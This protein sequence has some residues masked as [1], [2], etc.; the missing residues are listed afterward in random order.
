MIIKEYQKKSDID[1]LVLL[2]IG[3]KNSFNEIYNRYRDKMYTLAF[4]YIKDREESA[5]IVQKVFVKIWVMHAE[6]NSSINIK[7]YLYTMTR[8]ALLNYIRDNT[9]RLKHNYMILQQKGDEDDIY[10]LAARKSAVRELLMAIK[11]LPMQQQKV[12]MYRCEGFSNMEISKKMNLS[13]NT[14]NTHYKQCLINLKKELGS[15][16]YIVLYLIFNI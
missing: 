3:D 1:L 7:S 15:I 11:K 5:D 2:K 6:L 4:R 12:A 9:S 13:L 10:E 16:L 8:N 14:I